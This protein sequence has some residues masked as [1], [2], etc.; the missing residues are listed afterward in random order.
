M[1]IV[2]NKDEYRECNTLTE[3]NKYIEEK[4]ITGAKIYFQVVAF[5]SYE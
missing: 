2:K 5:K 3:C 1:Y 4:Q